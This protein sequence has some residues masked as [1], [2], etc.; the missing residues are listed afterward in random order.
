LPLC[1]LL[2]S[3]QVQAADELDQLGR[4][5]ISEFALSPRLGLQEP[6]QGGFEL[7]QSW[8]GF[9]WRRDELVRGVL[10]LGSSDLNAPAIWNSPEVRPS[11]GVSEAW[12]EGRSGFGDMRAGLLSIPQAFEGLSPDWSA[13]LPETR[14]RRKSWFI[15]RDFGLQLNWATKKWETSVTVHNG[16][17]AENKDG[18][19]W[20]TS[21]WQYKTPGGSGVLVTGSVGQTKSES[22]LTSLAGLAENRFVFDRTEKAKIRQGSVALFR[23]Q[24]RNLLLLEAGR[25]EI[26]QKEEKNSFFWAHLDAVWNWGSDASL[27]FRYELNQPD[28][29]DSK[30]MLK[31]PGL[32]VSYSS[33]DNLQS[34]TAF[35]SR[36]E[37]DPEVPSD[38]F[39]LIFRIHSLFAR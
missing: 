7:S 26:L 21:H 20:V 30:S 38:E 22:T 28:Q 10:K 8:I 1:F 6:G 16:E 14:A 3:L 13:V 32:G 24:R 5:E 36:L 39:W 19:Y 35:Y 9:E 17:S 25:G 23:E 27:L 33:K 15:K 11:F 12:M 4:F 18:Q 2:F 34:L 31:S 29:K 37:E